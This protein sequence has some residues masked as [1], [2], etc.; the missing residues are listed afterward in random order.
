[1]RL[2]WNEINNVE[3]NTNEKVIQLEREIKRIQ[4]TEERRQRREKRNNI[5]VK[6]KEIDKAS[7]PELVEKVKQS[8]KRQ[9]TT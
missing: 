9:K 1:M 6:S 7:P 4:E 2:T 3:N 5:V 8:Y